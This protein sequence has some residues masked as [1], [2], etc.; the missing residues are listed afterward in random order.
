MA[1][2]STKL[3]NNWKNEQI[4]KKVNR[5]IKKKWTN[6]Q[7]NALRNDRGMKENNIWTNTWMK[8]KWRNK[9]AR[10]TDRQTYLPPQFL[11]ILSLPLLKSRRNYSKEDKNNVIF[12]INHWFLSQTQN[13][14]SPPLRIWQSIENCLCSCRQIPENLIKFFSDEKIWIF[15]QQ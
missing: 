12:C 1:M 6:E 7:T 5:W 2:S 8:N 4:N 3:A 10:E 15:H 14:N 13:I 11:Q 9:Q